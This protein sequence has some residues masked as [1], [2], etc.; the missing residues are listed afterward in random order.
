MKNATEQWTWSQVNRRDTPLVSIMLTKRDF[1][2]AV[3]FPRP[4][5]WAGS[6]EADQNH[7]RSL[8][9]E[10]ANQNWTAPQKSA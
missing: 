10:A 7:V 2:A 9:L 6:G 1:S 3:T 5:G 8:L 4:A